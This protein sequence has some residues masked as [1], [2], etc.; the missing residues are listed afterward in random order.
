MRRVK[1][2]DDCRDLGACN[3]PNGGAPLPDAF[4]WRSLP[5]PKRLSPSPPLP[6]YVHDDDEDDVDNN[7]QA[8]SGARAP[9]AGEFAF[10][11]SDLARL[12]DVVD[13]RVHERFAQ[14]LTAL[15]LR[16]THN[17]Y[18]AL[19]DRG[20]AGGESARDNAPAA[21]AAYRDLVQQVA[22]DFRRFFYEA[23]ARDLRQ[24]RPYMNDTQ[25]DLLQRLLVERFGEIEHGSHAAIAAL[26]RENAALR[27]D[28]DALLAAAVANS[29]A[30]SQGASTPADQNKEFG[31]TPL[32]SS[33]S[34]R[35][36][37]SAR[38][39]IDDFDLY[40]DDD[41]ADFYASIGRNPELRF[42]PVARNQQLLRV[43]TAALPVSPPSTPRKP[44]PPPSPLR[45]SVSANDLTS[46]T[47]DNCQQ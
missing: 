30:K 7:G 1:S 40:D 9:G 24:Q 35:Y 10:S 2:C 33:S 41:V 26:Q 11:H 28:V 16:W 45:Q 23:W 43:A 37:E 8:R 31:A 4:R 44:K 19:F 12:M 32:T 5:L 6:F 20:N 13:Q 36:T 39:Y 22:Y 3:A 17:P 25:R 27:R 38:Q 21:A 15:E 29:A 47:T 14:E 42:A 18:M 34:K 46:E